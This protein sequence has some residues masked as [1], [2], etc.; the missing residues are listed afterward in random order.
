LINQGKPPTLNSSVRA[1]VK[2]VLDQRAMD[3]NAV[4]PSE[5]K[6]ICLE[7]IRK[8]QGLNTS[9]PVKISTRSLQTFRKSDALGIHSASKIS[10][11]R[12][13]SLRNL[14]KY[15]SFMGMIKVINDLVDKKTKY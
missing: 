15:L 5:F 8:D 4:E 2:A 3:I 10:Q 11:N 1:N 6:N 7:E 9:V 14:K 13:N 12:V